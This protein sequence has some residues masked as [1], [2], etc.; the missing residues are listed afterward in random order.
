VARIEDLPTREARAKALEGARRAARY[1]FAED[2]IRKIV[3][4]A[5]PLTPEQRHRLAA[6]LTA[7]GKTPTAPD[8]A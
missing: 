8:A 2:R 1:R 3:D 6:I 7:G 5:P 4:G